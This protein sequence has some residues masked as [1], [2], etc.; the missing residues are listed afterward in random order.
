[1][2]EDPRLTRAR[3]VLADFE[4]ATEDETRPHK[5]EERAGRLHGALADL[6]D[7][8]SEAGERT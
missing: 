7:Y 6:Y 5:P 2:T 8:T 4:A 1:M 3:E